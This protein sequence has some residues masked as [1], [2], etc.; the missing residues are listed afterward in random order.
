M[1]LGVYLE[2]LEGLNFTRNSS[3]SRF[4]I[5]SR[6]QQ[7]IL[8][9]TDLCIEEE[10][11][12]GPGAFADEL[13][14][15]GISPRHSHIASI[16]DIGRVCLTNTPACS[17][18]QVVIPDRVTSSAYTAPLDLT[19]G[20]LD[21]QPFCEWPQIEVLPIGPRPLGLSNLAI[22]GSSL[23]LAQ[24]EAGSEQ[25]PV[26]ATARPGP[27]WLSQ[28]AQNLP[29]YSAVPWRRVLQLV[30]VWLLHVGLQ[31]GRSH[32]GKCS[33]ASWGLYAT[34]LA[35]MSLLGLIFTLRCREE[36]KLKRQ[37][38]SESL[39]DISDK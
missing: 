4:N 37:Q 34:Q 18:S 27:A 32:V 9:L 25:L 1:S 33:A 17:S 8:G 11:Q 21:Y 24:G 31:L 13:G 38:L 5:S 39:P 2:S 16:Y 36:G 35:A 3:V 23:N 19:H 20:P 14:L 10:M 30:A 22:T 26:V 12:G 7:H 6:P 28:L 29:D 15:V